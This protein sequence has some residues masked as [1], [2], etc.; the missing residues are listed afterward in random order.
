VTAPVDP[1]RVHLHKHQ[2]GVGV[3]QN[4]LVDR[5]PAHLLKLLVMVVVVELHPPVR[6]KLSQ[7]VEELSTTQDVVTVAERVELD[8]TAD[9][10]VPDL[11][12]I[13]QDRRQPVQVQRID[14]TP[15]H[16]QTQI[17]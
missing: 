1:V 11:G 12:L 2:L 7:P 13:V 4:G 9:S 6:T 10:G 5:L 15:H 8:I 17:G 3:V 16:P 14:V